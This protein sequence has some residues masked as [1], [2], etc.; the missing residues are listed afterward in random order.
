MLWESFSGLRHYLFPDYTWYAI[1]ICPFKGKL[2]FFSLTAWPNAW[3]LILVSLVLLN[4][5]GILS[6]QPLNPGISRASQWYAA[7]SALNLS[8]QCKQSFSMVPA[9]TATTSCSRIFSM[10]WSLHP[11]WWTICSKIFCIHQRP[12]YF[13]CT[14]NHFWHLLHCSYFFLQYQSS[15]SLASYPQSNPV[16]H[17][18]IFTWAH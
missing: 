15:S 13:L 7:F 4:G 2:I 3:P 12:Q 9:L 14:T 6:A 18:P 16:G 10:P 8:F 17:I 11:L 1:T 5:T